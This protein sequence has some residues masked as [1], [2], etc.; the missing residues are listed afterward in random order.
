MTSSKH[1][2]TVCTV[3]LDVDQSVLCECAQLAVSGAAATACEREPQKLSVLRLNGVGA[4]LKRERI[5]LSCSTTNIL[6]GA[7]SMNR[8]YELTTCSLR[9]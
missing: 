4:Q 8:L 1:Q 6:G 7:E 3:L 9:P 5:T 2:V